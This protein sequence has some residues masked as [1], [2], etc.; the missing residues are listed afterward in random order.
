MSNFDKLLNHIKQ[1]RP[2]TII[3]DNFNADSVFYLSLI[4][5]TKLYTA[6]QII[7]CNLM[8][9]YN[10]P[11]EH[12]K[13]HQ[14]LI[15]ANVKCCSRLRL[16][17]SYIIYFKFT[18]AFFYL[19]S[20]VQLSEKNRLTSKGMCILLFDVFNRCSLVQL[21]EI[22]R[23]IIKGMSNI[24]YWEKLTFL[25]LWLTCREN[26]KN[27]TSFEEQRGT[28][29]V[30]G[31]VY[32]GIFAFGCLSPTNP[33]LRFLLICFAREIKGFYQSSLGNEIDFTDIMNVSQNI[34]AKN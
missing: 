22:N 15:F 31:H 10:P 21:K 4:S 2:S 29:Y 12:S 11:Y 23:L 28:R 30:R 6:L 1:F 16:W 20:L 18:H 34:L 24:Y 17:A 19:M 7:H 25:K 14:R 9:V 5:L 32:F 27:F 3:L 13:I 26:L 33:C 8:I